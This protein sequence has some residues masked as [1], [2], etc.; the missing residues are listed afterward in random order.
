M[1]ILRYFL[2][3]LVL[4]F[5]M[6]GVATALIAWRIETRYPPNGRFVDVAGGRLHYVEAGPTSGVPLGTVVL[7]HG[8]SSNSA[9]SM[10]S[11]GRR[12]AERYRVIAFDRPGHGWS[13][14][15]AGADAARPQRQAALIA[16]AMRKL[17][18]GKAIVAGH[19]WGGSVVPNFALDHPDVTGALMLLSAV[20]HPW[21]GGRITWYYHPA[22]SLIGW[23]FTRTLTTPLGSL[24]VGPSVA[25]VFAP[26]SPPQ[27]YAELAR[28]RLV[29]RPPVFH[30][31]AQDVAGLHD[32]VTEQSPRY[33][34]IRVPATAIG[35]DAD[36]IVWTDLHSRSFAREVAGTK[37]VVLP[38]VG[39]MPHYSHADL[40]IAEIDALAARMATPAA[41]ARAP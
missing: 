35:G 25:G 24:L 36:T 11:F 39:H 2:I 40:I 4:V 1:T 21:P 13:D 28:I 10:A 16:E 27:D 33:G 20:T 8:A 9:D 17:Q 19:S 32:A 34:A 37:L 7:L 23:L 22:T 29:L 41:E 31:N 26:Q 18:T 5:V 3:G 6:G 15:I 14:R 38:G 12:L 30:A